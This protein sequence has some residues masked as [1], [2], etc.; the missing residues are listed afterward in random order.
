MNWQSKI[1]YIQER[2]FQ[3]GAVK[4]FSEKGDEYKLDLLQNLKD[5]EITFYTQGNLLIS[6]AVRIFPIQ[7]L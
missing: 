1:I 4:Y 5:G 3:R 7:D 2:K 6:A